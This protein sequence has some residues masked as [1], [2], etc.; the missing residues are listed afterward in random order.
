MIYIL[1]N[2][3]SKNNN[4]KINNG[5]NDLGFGNKISYR[6]QRKKKANE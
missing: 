1:E 5:I 4:N 6:K 3:I 2:S